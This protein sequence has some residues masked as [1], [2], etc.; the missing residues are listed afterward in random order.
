MAIERPRAR[1]TVPK[2]AA[3]RLGLDQKRE[4]Q[5]V[6]AAPGGYAHGGPWAS[7]GHGTKRV[8]LYFLQNTVLVVSC[9]IFGQISYSFFYSK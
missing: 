2:R 5:Q 6:C 7:E 4:R 3:G 9:P 8:S 1:V